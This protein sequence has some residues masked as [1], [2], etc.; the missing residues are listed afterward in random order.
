MSRGKILIVEDDSITVE[1]VRLCLSREGFK[2]SSTGLGKEAV[3]M[4]KQIKPDL[5]V[6]DLILPDM[7]GMDICQMTKKDES[8]KHIPIVMLTL[9]GEEADIVKGL[10]EGA[11][12]YILKPFSPNIFIA[13]INAVL[14]R[15]KNEISDEIPTL[16]IHELIIDTAC[17]E[18]LIDGET[19]KLTYT[20]FVLLMLM[21]RKPG[22]I[23]TREEIMNVIWGK[24]YPVT[25]RSVDVQIVGLRKKLGRLAH[26]IETIRKVGYRFKDNP[27]Q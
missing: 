12:D 2:V 13:R 26:Y 18:I 5:I 25:G 9:K 1:F 15:N 21:V 16:K 11:D 3:K 20:E 24:N 22:V 14:R 27:D 4:I 8:T 23:Y 19:A 6:L 10:E 17:R 7:N